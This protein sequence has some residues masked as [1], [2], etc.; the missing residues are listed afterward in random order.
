MGGLGDGLPEMRPGCG[1]LSVDPDLV[2]AL[3]VRFGASVLASRRIDVAD[4]EDE[5]EMMFNRG[6]TDGL[7]VVPPTEERVMRMLDRHDAGPVATSSPPCRPTS[8]T[9]PS[10]R[11]RSPR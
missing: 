10:R 4:A 2:D 9:S 6:W 11:W 5:M 3:R 7:P 1:S 8:S